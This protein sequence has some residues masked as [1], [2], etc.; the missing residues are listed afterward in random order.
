[1]T[2]LFHFSR[3]FCNTQ[4]SE[5]KFLLKLK[6]LY[7]YVNFGLISMTSWLHSREIYNNN[8]KTNSFMNLP[9]FAIRFA[10]RHRSKC[11]ASFSQ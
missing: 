7:I 2:Q 11:V 9:I 5:A 1:M 10:S 6:C 4:Y 3:F 8:K